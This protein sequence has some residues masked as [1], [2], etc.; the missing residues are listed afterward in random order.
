MQEGHAEF[1]SRPHFHFL[2]RLFRARDMLSGTRLAKHLRG[3][4]SFLDD[5][6][7]FRRETSLLGRR[8]I[9]NGGE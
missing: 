3:R 7:Q 8:G 6:D 1:G 4:I 2:Q 5:S 9:D